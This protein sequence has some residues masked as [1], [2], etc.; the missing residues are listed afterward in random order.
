MC[1]RDRISGLGTNIGFKY[2]NPFKIT[3][4]YRAEAPD[5]RDPKTQLIDNEG[6]ELGIE[7]EEFGDLQYAQIDNVSGEQI[8]PKLKDCYLTNIT[9]NYNPTSMSFHSDGRPVEI[10]LSLSF[11][12]Q[13][14]LNRNDIEN[15]KTGG[16]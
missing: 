7:G 4:K 14:T 8:G 15:P 16:Y 5:V 9:T 12:E 6:N 2:P 10:D 3:V 13:T 11:T 1:I